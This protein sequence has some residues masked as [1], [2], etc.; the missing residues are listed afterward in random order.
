[1]AMTRSIRLVPLLIAPMVAA[2]GASLSTPAHAAPSTPPAVTA[3]ENPRPVKA[4][5]KAK[6]KP[7]KA[8]KRA[9]TFSSKLK[10]AESR[11][12]WAR[13]C[14]PEPPLAPGELV[15]GGGGSGGGKS[16]PCK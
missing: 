12:D 13:S 7:V 10:G 4:I 3:D 8:I 11:S 16:D 5:G 14:L 15:G 1:M 9:D 6:F 2:A